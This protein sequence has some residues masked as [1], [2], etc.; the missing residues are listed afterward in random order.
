LVLE[1]VAP[2][3]PVTAR[4]TDQ[5]PQ[6]AAPGVDLADAS[7]AGNRLLY[8]MPLETLEKTVLVKERVKPQPNEP[9][10]NEPPKTE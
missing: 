8:R 6:T 3:A 10:P 2:G 1:A 7:S 4:T 5:T 9:P